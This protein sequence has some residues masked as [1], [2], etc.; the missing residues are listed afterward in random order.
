MSEQSLRNWVFTREDGNGSQPQLRSQTLKRAV[1]R[2]AKAPGVPLIRFHDPRH[3]H[4]TLML[5]A[6]VHPK[7]VQERLGHASIQI[8]LDTY[9]HVMP[10]MQEDAAAKVGALVFG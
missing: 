7:V 9:S 1:G 5:S 8:T 10:G 3:T 2:A 4:A 6:G